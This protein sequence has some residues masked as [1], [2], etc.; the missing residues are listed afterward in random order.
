G[1]GDA[2]KEVRPT[3]P[4][5]G[6]ERDLVE[7]GNRVEV[8]VGKEKSGLRAVD[9]SQIDAALLVRAVRAVY[10]GLSVGGEPSHPEAGRAEG[11]LPERGRDGGRRTSPD[12]QER[13]DR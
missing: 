7:P 4:S 9:S 12:R 5:A 3:Q 2:R 11:Q 10:D 8:G 6:H 1:E 13:D